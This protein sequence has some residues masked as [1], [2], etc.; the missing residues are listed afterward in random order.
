MRNVHWFLI[1]FF[2]A[3]VGSLLIFREVDST[4]TRIEQPI[5]YREFSEQ[6]GEH[7]KPIFE[8]RIKAHNLALELACMA[9]NIYNEAGFESIEGQLAV[10]TVVW[11]RVKSPDYPKTVCGVVYERHVDFRNHKVVCQFSWTC[12]PKRKLNKK[13]YKQSREI[14]REV[15]LKHRLLADVSGATLYHAVYVHPDWADRTEQIGQI[16]THLFYRE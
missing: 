4:S 10:A 11:N 9:D 15:L 1:T 5:T 2:V 14:A 16:G 7:Y 8:K 6:L 12:K 3:I 13:K